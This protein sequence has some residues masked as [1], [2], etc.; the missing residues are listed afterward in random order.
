MSFTSMFNTWICMTF[1]WNV[2]QLG[3]HLKTLKIFGF[4]F[5]EKLNPDYFKGE[6]KQVGE[7]TKQGQGLCKSL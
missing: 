3:S 6:N 2:F 1:T 7:I 4:V 5:K